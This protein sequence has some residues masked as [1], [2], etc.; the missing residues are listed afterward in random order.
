MTKTKMALYSKSQS[1]NPNY[2][3]KPSVSCDKISKRSIHF[4]VPSYCPDFKRMVV[5]GPFSAHNYQL[6]SFTTPI[7]IPRLTLVL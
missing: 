4:Y 2:Q 3:T 6:E 1:H 7:F 5:S